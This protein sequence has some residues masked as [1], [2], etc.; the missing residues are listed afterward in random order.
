MR[1]AVCDDSSID[2][3]L[4]VAVLHHYFV[5]KPISN[6]IVQYENGM[7]LLHDV[8]DD[9]WFDIIF[10]D[11]YMND[12]L[13][14]DVAHKLRSLGYRGHIIFLTATA[15][16]AVDSYEVEALGY[17]LKPQ[18]LEK[19]SQVMDR[20]IRG[21]TANTYQVKKHAKIIRV[22]YHEI[23]YVESMNSKC[24][25]HC[26]DGQS[27]VI[28]KRLTN[29]EHEL[30]DARFLRCHQSYLVNMDCIHQVDTQFT[31]VTGDTVAIRQRDL[32]VIRQTALDYLGSTK[33]HSIPESN[34]LP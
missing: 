10:L 33:P 18:S 12:L 29:I 2:R 16:F 7:D 13:G 1:V 21:M 31:L 17:L 30:N 23:L 9:M 8:E 24:I 4:F 27:Y 28:Y 25:M 11:I 6:E 22:P 3:E 14:I 19:L 26:R 5:N 32:K 34:A 20:A 15:D